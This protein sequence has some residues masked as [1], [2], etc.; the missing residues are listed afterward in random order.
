M[1]AVS[2]PISHQYLQQLA[3]GLQRLSA[4]QSLSLSNN[5]IGSES[6]ETLC[7]HLSTV[8]TLRTL[9]LTG[10]PLGNAGM[11]ALGRFITKLYSLQ[12]LELC[13]VI[14]AGEDDA[15]MA[16]DTARYFGGFLSQCTGL[17]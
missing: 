9:C 2:D 8:S 17:V 5:G 11:R 1:D 10:N 4:L 16:M 7:S 12:Q 3:S 13:G 6:L 15:S 14:E